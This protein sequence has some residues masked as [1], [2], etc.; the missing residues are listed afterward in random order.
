MKFKTTVLLAG[1]LLAAAGSFAQISKGTLFLGGS[2]GYNSDEGESEM[3]KNKS[4]NFGATISF[5]KAVGINKIAGI[6]IGY[7]TS[8]AEQEYNANSKNVSKTKAPNAGF[9]Y[10]QYFPLSTKWYLFGNASAGY[11]DSR[12]ENKFNG[13]LQNKNSGK[14]IAAGITPGISFQASK[15]LHIE[16]SLLDIF[17]IGYGSGKGKA[18][19]ASGNVVST[20]KSNSFSASANLS[21]FNNINIGL[22]WMIP[23]RK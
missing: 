5:G 4:S 11:Y 1:G 9:F 21:A 15:R 10:R 19:D 8:S 16:T 23:P 2:A 13:Q 3:S 20:L 22:R 17:R 7:N 18:Y 12:S 6:F 14:S